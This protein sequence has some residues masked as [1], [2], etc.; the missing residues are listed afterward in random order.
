[1]ELFE[2]LSYYGVF[3]L[4]ANYLT[5]S[6]DV[7]ALGFSQIEKAVL[8]GSL[9]SLVYLLP[10]FT[11]AIAD[12]F[13]YKRVLI[14]AYL[15]LASGYF[16]LGE[17]KSFWALYY[18]LIYIAI[19]AALFKPV[20]SAT[21]SKTT[22]DDNSSIG[23]GIF[24]MM[25]NVGSLIG[26]F[27]GAKLKYISYDYVFYISTISILLNLILV[28][29]FYKEP[30]RKES[31][32]TLWA[33]LWKVVENIFKVFL[34]WKFVIFILLMGGFWSMYWQ[35]FYAVP[36]FI[37]QWVDL[38]AFYQTVYNFS[39]ALANIAG[40]NG[41][42]PSEMIVN[43]DSLFI[44]TFQVLVSYI[45]MRY[46]PLNAMISGIII[47]SLGIGLM[48]MTNNPLF[49]VSSLLIFAW[50]EMASSP[51]ITEYIGKI[52]PKDKVA[53]YMGFSFFPHFI[54]N[55]VTSF[56]SGPVYQKISDKFT[57]AQAEALE[58]GYTMPEVSESFSMNDYYAS[59]SAQMDMNLNEMTTYL[60]DKYEPSNF[61]MILTGIGLG[62][63]FLLFIYDK[64]ILKSKK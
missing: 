22:N 43:M 50:G 26:P 16:M 10:I 63:S 27:I 39:P 13:G 47:C 9:G 15:I 54:G 60:W 3:I 12:R 46:K 42:I 45:V 21:I 61:W 18:V 36:V 55:I 5:G 64:Y 35:L 57:F 62:T 44:I 23:F 33:S 29:L 25:V 49:M 31:K 38:Q 2:R 19:G 11:G 37:E 4:L 1:M 56:L 6:T 51:K 32:E 48:L 28:I 24:Y 41:S 34:D 53:L 14:V 58:R 52:A 30:D 20:I 8:M 7:G 40:S 17:F 59:L